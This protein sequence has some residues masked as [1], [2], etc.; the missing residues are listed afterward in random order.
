MRRHSV[1]LAGL[2]MLI[3]LGFILVLHISPSSADSSH[4]N[5][6]ACDIQTGPCRQTTHDGIALE[7][8]ILPKPVSAMR[9][10]IFRITLKNRAGPVTNASVTID[11]SMPGMYMG[12]NKITLTPR[13]GVYE[14]TGI[15]VRC[16]SGKKTWQADV[17]IRSSGKS[18]V[19]GFIF[20]VQ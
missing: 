11:L 9:E 2:H 7:F 20:E 1:I 13:D 19:T 15:I 14:G 4:G 3:A 6:V 10:L 12:N 18:A 16:P 5:T 8:D 17:A